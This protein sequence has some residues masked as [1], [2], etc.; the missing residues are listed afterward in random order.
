MSGTD[1]A[2]FLAR[3]S[4][5][6]RAVVAD[7]PEDLATSPGPEELA[8]TQADE[9]NEDLSDFEILEKLGLPDPESLKAGD[10]FSGFMANTVPARLRNKALRRLWLSN[11]VLANLDER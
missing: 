10:D 8:A 1:D 4:A 9:I 6:K 11:P 7:E 2:G 5:R 3:W